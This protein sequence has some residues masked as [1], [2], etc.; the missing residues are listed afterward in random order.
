MH[1]TGIHLKKKE[2][3]TASFFYHQPLTSSVIA[4]GG[5]IVDLIVHLNMCALRCNYRHV[6]GFCRTFRPRAGAPKHDWSCIRHS[7]SI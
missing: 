4:R 1:R 6:R 5:R 2:G 7:N 3:G